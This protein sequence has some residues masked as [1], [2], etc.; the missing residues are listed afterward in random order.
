VSVAIRSERAGTDSL[1]AQIREA[2]W[3]VN[4]N[5]PLAQVRTLD[6]LLDQS[7]ARTSFTLVMLAIAG[8][9]A[10]LL[11]I[12]GLYG[13]ISY[14]VSRRRREIGIRMALGAQTTDIR[15]LFMRR[16]LILIGIGVAVGLGA[17]AGFA[18]AMRSLLFGVGPLDPITFAMA[19]IVLASAAVLATYLPARRAVAVDP[20]KI[21]RAE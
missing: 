19:P 11:G 12:V 2:V 16:G 18:P 3:S 9:M 21:L 15:A 20:I 10:L 6:A 7:M 13:V 4:P 8:A 5:L 14:A 1:L 17:A